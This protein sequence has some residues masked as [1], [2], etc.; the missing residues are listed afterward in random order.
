MVLTLIVLSHTP[1][2]KNTKQIQTALLLVATLGV[3]SGITIVSFLP[4]IS[5][6]FSDVA[7]IEFLSKLMLTIPSIIIAL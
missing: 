3:M 2:T 4:L 1:M 7:N 5:H 6:T